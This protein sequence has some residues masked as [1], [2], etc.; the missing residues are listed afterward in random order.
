LADLASGITS[1]IISKKYGNTSSR[2]QCAPHVHCSIIYHSEDMKTTYP[3]KDEWIRKSS[4]IAKVLSTTLKIFKN[5]KKNK[6]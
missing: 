1:E 6:R 4:V 3:S 2:R 5:S